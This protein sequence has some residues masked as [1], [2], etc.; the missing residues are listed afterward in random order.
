MRSYKQF[1]PLTYSVI[2]STIFGLEFNYEDLTVNQN[3][4]SIAKI[5]SLLVFGSTD[6]YYKSFA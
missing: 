1:A 5:Y 4:E 2:N 6:K 3:P